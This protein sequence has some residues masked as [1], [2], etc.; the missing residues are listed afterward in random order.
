MHNKTIPI[1]VDAF[2][3]GQ[4][5]SKMWLCDELEKLALPEPLNIWVY[6]GWHGVMSFL[7]LSRN[8]IDIHTIRS[9]DIDPNCHLVA[10]ALNENW[11]WQQWKFKAFTA[12]CNAIDL[13]TVIYGPIPN[14]IINTSTE[15]MH[16][17]QW[18][19]KIPTGMITVLQSNNMQHDH[20]DP[21][22][23]NLDDFDKTYPMQNTKFL[24]Q[25][26]F[27]YATWN[28]SRYMKIGIK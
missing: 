18:Y 21:G 16:S 11:V 4:I 24:G 26:N 7:L 17:M 5:A 27:D 10:D 28:F 22:N 12:D 15:H 14:L 20:H 9:F 3:S 25:L 23:C 6:G 8:N 13:P 2:S 19:D 1:D